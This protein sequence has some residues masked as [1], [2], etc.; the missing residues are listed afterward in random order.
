MAD[1]I[2]Q[3]DSKTL[4]LYFLKQSILLESSLKHWAQLNSEAIESR[5]L[6]KLHL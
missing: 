3:P 2:K 1:V 5:R 4:G 6:S